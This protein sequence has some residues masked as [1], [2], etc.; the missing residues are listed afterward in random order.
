M[1]TLGISASYTVTVAGASLFLS[2]NRL[3]LG[4]RVPLGV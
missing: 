3:N 4:Y 2:D 1:V